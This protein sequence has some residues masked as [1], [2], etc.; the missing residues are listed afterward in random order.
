M[1]V[2]KHHL[3]E[4]PNLRSIEING[5]LVTASTNPISSAVDCDNLQSQL[6]FTLPEMTFGSNELK[7]DHR[8]T[9]WHYSFTT[10]GAL[11][12]VKKGHLVDGDGGVKVEYA[13]VWLK[14]RW[15]PFPMQ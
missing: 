4:S 6:G 10:H 12:S 11:K 5:W 7:L 2:P 14:S 15:G 8:P 1:S 3:Y 9:G 13:D